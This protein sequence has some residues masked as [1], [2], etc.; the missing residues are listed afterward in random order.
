MGIAVSSA[1]THIHT[2]W[3]VPHVSEYIKVRQYEVT[4]DSSYPTGGEPVTAAD[5]GFTT[6]YEIWVTQPIGY[7]I[8]WDMD[9]AKFKVYSPAHRTPRDTVFTITHDASAATNGVAV[10]AH[11]T[12]DSHSVMD[13][14][15]W[16]E[17]VSPTDT[18][19]EDV[20]SDLHLGC[21]DDNAA[22]AG[23]QGQL[24]VAPAGGG[25]YADILEDAHVP[26]H[27]EQHAAIIADAD[28][29][30]NQSAVPVFFDEDATAGT[31]FQAV[32]ADAADEPVTITHAG[33]GA[34]FLNPV[35]EVAAA[36]DLSG[37]TM[38]V[39]VMGY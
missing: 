35:P 11:Y 9:N 20:Q 30:S 31:R 33:D 36:Q 4:F 38:R 26:F 37:L 12:E 13:N 7:Q 29:A 14:N 10:Y 19:G 17:F 1:V 22:A 24:H 15:V 34:I 3:S 18:H 2:N 39:L 23:F 25:F 28:P 16:L 5:F 27:N 8:E 21:V 6:L 32:V